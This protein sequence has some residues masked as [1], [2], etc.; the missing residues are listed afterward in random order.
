MG[1]LPKMTPQIQSKWGSPGQASQSDSFSVE[2]VPQRPTVGE[3]NHERVK[4]SK[5]FFCVR[6]IL[7]FGM[8]PLILPPAW[9]IDGSSIRF[10]RIVDLSEKW[11]SVS[12]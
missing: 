3:L 7:T 8:I 2:D 9:Q 1:F 10:G 5:Y 11:I 12:N 6:A 4:Q